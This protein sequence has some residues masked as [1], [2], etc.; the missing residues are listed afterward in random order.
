MRSRTLLGLSLSLSV[1]LTQAAC[2]SNSAAAPEP[3]ASG[4]VSS[5]P[6]STA[7]STA[8]LPEGTLLTVQISNTAGQTFTGSL[9]Q[10]VLLNGLEVAGK[11]ARVEGKIVEA[12]KGGKVTAQLT[13]LDVGG[14]FIYLSTNL[15]TLSTNLVTY[16]ARGAKESVLAFALSAP[17]TLT[18]AS[19]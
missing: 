3:V 19:R 14:Q 9:E 12:D 2:G 6:K 5:L 18:V 7:T 10:P 17:I 16:D 1:A 8:I 13:G 15:V 4:K 11:G